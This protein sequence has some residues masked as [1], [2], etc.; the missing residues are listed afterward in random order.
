MNRRMR[1]TIMSESQ[2]PWPPPEFEANR[3]KIPFES[4]LPYD[5]MRI[6]YS[7]DG[8]RI[9]DG[10]PELGKLI[11]RL[12]AAGIDTNRVVFDFFECSDISRVGMLCDSNISR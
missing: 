8:T 7:W 4:F 10:D 11:D 1:T 6:A 9:L 3:D 5:G 12:E 2:C